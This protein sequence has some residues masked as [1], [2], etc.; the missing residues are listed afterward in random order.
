MPTSKFRKFIIGTALCT[1]LSACGGG[2]GGG[3]V[4]TVVNTFINDDFS[5][6]TGS[7]SII[8]SYSSLLSGFQS[9]I[10]SGNYSSLSAILTGPD[11]ED[12]AKANQLLTMLNQAETLWSETL[13]LIDSQDND[14]KL[15]IYNSEDYKNAHAAL[16][17][18]KNH[19]KPVIEKVSSGK[20]V[21]LTEYNKVAKT[22]K[23][24]EIIKIEKD[25]TVKTYVADKKAKINEEKAKVIV[26]KEVK[27]EKKEEVKEEV[28]E[29]KKEEVKEEKKVEEKK[30]E[31]KKEESKVVEKEEKKEE[32]KVVKNK[33]SIFKTN[34]YNKNSSFD[35]INASKAYDKG[36]TGKGAVLGVIDTYQ[37]TDHAELKNKYLWY[38]DYTRYDDTVEN[39]GKYV[40]HGT[41]VAGIVAGNKDNS[42]MHGVAFD[43]K[44]VGAN[45]DYTGN[46]RISKS[47]AQ[48][49][50][51]DFAKLK[52]PNGENLNIVA[53]NM[54]FNT[55]SLFKKSANDYLP[56]TVVKLN[57]G[58]FNATEITLRVKHNDGQAKYYKVATDNDMI[59]VNSAGNSEFD[60]ASDPGIWATEV[61]A[62]GNLILGGK[63]VIV[64]NWDTTGQI[65]QGNKAGH[66]CLDINTSNNTCNDKH[67]IS[68]FYILAPGQEIYSAVSDNGYVNMSGTSMA[69]PHVT[70]AFGI[71][72]EMWPHMKG[73][74]LVQLVLTTA[75]KD[76]KEYD[77]NTHGQGLLDLDEAT[78]PQGVVGIPTT[79]R[80]NGPVVNVYSTYFATGTSLPSNLKNLKVM[81]LDGYERDYYVNLGSNFTVTDNRK[82]SDIEVMMDGHTYLPVQ[83]MYGSWAQGGN[84]DLG[85]MNFGVY[86][87]ENGNGDFS[88]NIGKHF[89]LTNN[90]KFKTSIG[91]MNEQ[92]TWLGN[93][94]DGVLAVGDNNTTN[95]G[96]LG[97]EYNLGN[98]IISFDYSKGYTDVNT[99]NNSL[100]TGFDNIETE[101]MKLGYE[102][103]HDNNNSYGFTASIP[104][105]I[106]KGTMN[107]DVP[108]SRTL[109]GQV[110]YTTINSNMAND[111]YEKDI[112]FYF[113]H[114]PKNDGD[115]SLKLSTEYRQDIAGQKDNNGVE[116]GIHFIKKLNW[117]CQFLYLKNPKCFDN[118]GSLKANLYDYD[119]TSDTATAMAFA[120]NDLS[121]SYNTISSKSIEEKET[122][123]NKVKNSKI[124]KWFKKK[125][126]TQ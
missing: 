21:S 109:D 69:A 37:Q 18:L 13:E 11:S 111:T 38:N 110:N 10:S 75:N 30:K 126:W 81:V 121:T 103:K 49:A 80:T 96:Q 66:V 59:L 119:K 71:L 44:L 88:A 63:M 26:K 83:T 105:H 70:G 24:E 67:R 97:F 40:P 65:V 9:T 73:E 7:E 60:F 31:E 91:Q 102:I 50:L 76:I 4:A 2:S 84:Y 68:D 120:S 107:L 106:T 90:L 51:H 95:F 29:E 43:S 82:V 53:V 93:S 58:T 14:T 85:Y 77:V 124:T 72:N 101:S 33:V 46:G 108:E 47:K 1:T 79:G 41:H 8:N 98:N 78:K 12:I 92:D 99:T 42:G 122:V 114:T 123:L 32:K 62:S 56:T 115:F 5:N 3:P 113:K 104:S 48:V 87:G 16:L 6:L 35:S 94:S 64:G 34:E 28:K 45:V 116:F 57:D 100:I 25:D 36:Y 19:V 55:P 54:S 15:Q 20:R 39:K 125:L 89:D 27:E 61:D 22:D 118:T 17:Y 52:D 74:N 112:G 117:N 86:S 23:A